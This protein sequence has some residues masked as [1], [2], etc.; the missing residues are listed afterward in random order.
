MS[1]L[2]VFKPYLIQKTYYFCYIRIVKKCAEDSTLK[3]DFEHRVT[4]IIF[5]IR[6]FDTR[7]YRFT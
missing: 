5:E 1:Y 6:E 3:Y 7:E 2:D 4:L